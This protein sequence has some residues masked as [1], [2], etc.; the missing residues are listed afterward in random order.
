MR[1]SASEA[2]STRRGAATWNARLLMMVPAVMAVLLAFPH[3]TFAQRS[4]PSHAGADSVSDVLAFEKQVEEAVLRAD[5]AF[6]DRVCASDFTYTHGDGWTTGGP[7]L[8]VDTKAEWLASLPGRYALRE[9]D[10][11]HVE[12]HGDVAITMDWV[13]SHRRNERRPACLQFLVYPGLRTSGRS[14]A[15]SLA[16]HGAWSGVRRVIRAPVVPCDPT[17][18][19]GNRPL[20]LG[21]CPGRREEAAC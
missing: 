21:A 5:V 4:P 16:S 10:S 2:G 15:V 1:G 11:Q 12:I 13:R 19:V 17:G 3:S 8:G 20:A 9:V 7:T 18:G 6:L 14:V